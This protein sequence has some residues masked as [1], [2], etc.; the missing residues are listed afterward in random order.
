M[1]SAKPSIEATHPPA[2]SLITGIIETAALDADGAR[3]AASGAR[4]RARP[5]PADAATGRMVGSVDW[6]RGAS[7][8][9][10]RDDALAMDAACQAFLA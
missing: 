10:A 2:N 9:E 1:T 5:P 4:G 3:R 6:R 7:A 8:P